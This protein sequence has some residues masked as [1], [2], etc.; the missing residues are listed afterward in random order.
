MRRWFYIRLVLALIAGLACPIVFTIS[1]EG[2]F[3]PRQYWTVAQGFGQ[4]LGA[5]TSESDGPG[6]ALLLLGSI[7]VVQYLFYVLMLM[8]V[9]TLSAVAYRRY[10]RMGA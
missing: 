8:I 6:W 5:A 2:E 7:Y 4:I 3:T 10:V 9:F 1:T